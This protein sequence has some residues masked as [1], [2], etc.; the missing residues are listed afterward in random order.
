MNPSP[1]APLHGLLPSTA[2]VLAALEARIGQLRW[3]AEPAFQMIATYDFRDLNAALEEL[4]TASD[5]LCLILFEGEQFGNSRSGRQLT[6]RRNL[7]VTLLLADQHR[8]NRPSAV[9]GAPGTAGAVVLK[10]IVLGLHREGTGPDGEPGRSVL[11]LLVPP[12]VV[13]P[14]ASAPVSWSED[15]SRRSGRG[16]WLLLLEI[17]GGQL[18]CD[19]GQPPIF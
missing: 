10:D 5:R 8:A 11:G 13:Q 2:V 16:A 15:N 19:L 14:V 3:G 6:V 4:Q 12:C 7:R 17:I 18:T 1:V 9:F